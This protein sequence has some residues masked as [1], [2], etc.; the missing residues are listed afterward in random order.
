MGS[1]RAGDDATLECGHLVCKPLVASAG[2]WRL[3][4][5]GSRPST[6]R[7]A[8]LRSS[9]TLP[10]QVALGDVGYHVRRHVHVV[11]AIAGR[12]L[13]HELEEKQRD[14]RLRCA[15]DGTCSVATFSR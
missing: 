8:A 7:S 14:I 5:F 11:A 15:S 12:R 1:E 6:S 10:G 2:A 9:R 4:R 3:L 13:P